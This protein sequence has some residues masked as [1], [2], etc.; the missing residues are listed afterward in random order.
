[1]RAAL[2]APVVSRTAHFLLQHLGDIGSALPASSPMSAAI[3]LSTDHAPNQG[4]SVDK[5]NSTVLPALL[6]VGLVVPKRHARR[7]VTRNLIK[8]QMREAMLRRSLAAGV[9]LIRLR[10]GFDKARYPSAASAALRLAV[11]EELEL[12]FGRLGA[13]K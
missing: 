2:A 3:K 7:A 1:M 6:A 13:A 9:W 5:A 10:V 12:L 4:R 11:H 8:R